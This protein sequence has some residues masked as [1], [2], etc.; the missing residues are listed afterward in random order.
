MNNESI[1]ERLMKTMDHIG[2]GKMIDSLPQG[3]DTP[4][5]KIKEN[6]QDLSGG[7]WQ[8]VAIARSLISPAPLKILD[9]PTAAIDPIEETRIFEKFAEI[10]KGKT[11]IIV[12]HRLGSAK[13]ADRIIVMDEGR[14][15]ESGTHEE[16]L[17]S[18]GRYS[19]MYAAQARWYES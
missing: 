8:R 11:S 12:T 19:M 17:K 2:L 7:Q 6:G 16:L 1:N 5:G 9:E 18:N 13:I 10:S 14:I 3:M 4:M 15:I